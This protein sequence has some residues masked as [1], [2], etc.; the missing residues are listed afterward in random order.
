MER[1]ELKALLLVDAGGNFAPDPQAQLYLYYPLDI[2]TGFRFLIH[3]FFLVN[4]ERT[5]LRAN[6]AAN[7]FLLRRI[8]EFIGDELFEALS[9][10]RA[11]THEILQ[12]TRQEPEQLGPL[13][14]TTRDTLA[15]KPFVLDTA[16]D[17]YR[18]IGEVM[19]T[20]ASEL[21]AIFPRNQVSERQLVLVS[22]TVRDWLVREFADHGAQE[23]NE[24]RAWGQ[25]SN[26]VQR[27]SNVQ[28]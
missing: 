12:F 9:R 22:V 25:S 15:A 14:D 13:Y 17:S 1:V 27:H 5:R 18:R 10:R 20:T 16:T 6:S 2:R 26:P 24:A 3:S 19:L 8:G 28:K 4:P 23:L 21:V 7:L 11:V